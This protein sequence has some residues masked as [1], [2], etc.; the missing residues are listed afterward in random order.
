MNIRIG[1]HPNDKLPPAYRR[2]A[3]LRR[4]VANIRKFGVPI[5]V[6][7]NRFDADT[8]D[9]VQLVRAILARQFAFLDWAIAL[10]LSYARSRPEK[11]P[12]IRSAH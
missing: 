4:H 1:I 5:V 12:T 11:P 3:N 8:P 7:I 9:E 2:A 6:A 10:R